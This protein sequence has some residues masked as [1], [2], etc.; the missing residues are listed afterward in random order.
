MRRTLAKAQRA[1][2]AAQLSGTREV[3]IE[4][5]K[6]DQAHQDKRQEQRAK[7][8]CAKSGGQDAIQMVKSQESKDQGIPPIISA[9]SHYQDPPTPFRPKPHVSLDTTSKPINSP[10]G[11]RASKEVTTYQICW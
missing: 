5:Q 11:N 8:S 4:I 6:Y 9:T 7:L 3:Y 2:A 1:S 10:P